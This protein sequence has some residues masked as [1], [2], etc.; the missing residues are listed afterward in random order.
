[1]D[2]GSATQDTLRDDLLWFLERPSVTGEEAALCDDL[3]ARI[4]EAPGWNVE[5]AAN[6][7]VVTRSEP[8]VSRERVV[9]AGHLDT[10]PEPAKGLRVRFEDG[11]IYGRGATDMKAGDA[12]MLSLLERFTWN[13]SDLEPVFVFYEREEGPFAENG[14]ETVFSQMP[15]SRS[16]WSRPKAR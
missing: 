3:E 7:L 15:G 8:D 4:G 12:V 13:E 9:L 16:C 5:R 2:T 14:L 6:N 11:L 10:V 1:L